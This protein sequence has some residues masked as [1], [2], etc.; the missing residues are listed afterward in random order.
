MGR[1]NGITQNGTSQATAAYGPASEMTSLSYYGYSETRT[2]DN[3]LQSRV[4]SIPV[5]S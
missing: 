3:L 5:L 1:M 4:A 2:Y